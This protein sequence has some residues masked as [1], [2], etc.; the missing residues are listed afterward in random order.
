MARQ[1]NS[2]SQLPPS[3]PRISDL[4]FRAD[5]VRFPRLQPAR[6]TAHYDLHIAALEWSLDA[7]IT[8]GSAA[9]I[10]S[11]RI[12]EERFKPYA[13]QVRNLITFCRRA[14]VALFADDVGL[15]KTISAGLVLSE[16][17]ERRK[18]SRALVVAPRI[19]LP[20]WQEELGTKFDIPSSTAT[21]SQLADALRGKAPVVITT[22][23]SVRGHLD[24]IGV[25]D[26]DMVIL[27]E[28][29]KLRNLHGTA[30]A[31]EFALSVRQ[32]LEAR[33]FKYVLMLTA[34]PIQN[35]LWDLYSLVDLLTVAKG[36]ENPLGSPG[37]F[38]ANYV[39]DTMAVEIRHGRREQF[40]RHL[41]SYIVRTRRSDAKLVFPQ[42]KVKTERVRPEAVELELLT[43]VGGLFRGG[44]LNGLTQSS[45]GQALMSSPAALVA[46]LEEMANRKTVPSSVARE[47]AALV[48][49]NV[50]SGKLKGL[51]ALVREL[52]EARPADWR[53]VV[54][55]SRSKTQEMV[56]RH[57]KSLGIPV[58]YIAGGRASENERSIRAFRKKTPEV[59]VLISTDAGAE[60]IN[61]QV[62]N[63]LVNYDLPWNP[64][65]L[66]QRIGRIQRLASE[67]A[68]VNILNLVLK[69][70]VEE[71]VVGRLGEK[72]HA[73]A[74]SMG[75]IEGI[76]ETTWDADGTDDSFESMIRK[77]VVDSL[78]GVDVQAAMRKAMA[79][80]QEAQE[81]YEAERDTVEKT[82]GDLEDW[83]RVGAKVPDIS[84]VEPSI[85]AK[86]F[87][88][89]A[90]RADGAFIDAVEDEILSVAT[91]GK[92]RFLMTFDPTALDYNADE[93]L[94]SG[95]RPRLFL[96]GKRDF[97]RLAQNWADKSGALVVDR[98]RPSVAQLADAVSRWLA[99]R[100]YVK[101]SRVTSKAITEG[102]EGE[103]TCRASVAVA[104]DRLEKLV[105]VA[106]RRGPDC[107]VDPP[108]ASEAFSDEH[109]E[110]RELGEGLRALVTEAI[111]DEPDLARFADFYSKRL[112]EEIVS[113]ADE[114][115]RRG[116]RERFTPAIGAEAV[117]VRG[118]R[119]A[120][121]QVE[122][123]LLIDGEGPYEA[124]FQIRTAKFPYDVEAQSPWVVC[125]Q[126]HREVPL[127]ATAVCAISDTRALS[128]LLAESPVSHR[129]A[130]ISLMHRCDESG[131]LLLPHEIETCGVT[132]RRV[133]R[134][135][136][137]SSDLSGRK[138][139]PGELVECDFTGSKVLP[140]ELAVS[141]VSGRR[142]RKDQLARS[143]LTQ[144]QGHVSEFVIATEPA[145][146]LAIDEAGR[147]AVSGRWA[148]HGVLV[149]SEVAPDRLG[150]PDE[151]VRSVVS[152]RLGLLDEVDR[153]A[154]SAQPALLS[155]F[156]RCA[157]TGSHCLPGELVQSAVSGLQFR[158]D[159]SRRSVISGRIA[160]ESEIVESID[161]QG[162]LCA[163]EAARSGVSGAWVAADRLVASAL[164]PERRALPREMV[165]SVL[166]GALMM[167]DEARRSP[168]SQRPA[169]PTEFITCE[170]TGDAVLPDELAPSAVSGR[171][172]RLD[173]IVTSVVSGRT[174]HSSEFVDSCLPQGLI[175]R[176]EAEQSV[177]SGAT[178]ARSSMVQSQE[179]PNRWALPEETTTSVVSGGV[180][181]RDEAVFS[182]LGGGPAARRELVPCEF[183]GD[184]LLPT[185]LSASQISG[186]RFR[187]DQATKSVHSGRI[188]HRSEFV[189][190]TLPQG[191]IAADEA[192]TSALSG[193]R[194]ARDAMLVSAAAGERIGLPEEFTVSAVSGER[195]LR[196]E[197]SVSAVSGSPAGPGELSACG[198]TGAQVLPSE[199]LRSDISRKLFRCDEATE[200]VV[201]GR[202][203]HA[204]EF[205]PSVAPSGRI[206]IDEA[207]RS[208]LSGEWG[209]RSQ[210]VASARQPHRIGLPHQLLECEI[211][212]R[213]LL[214]D[215]LEPSVVS[216]RM[217]DSEL[218]VASEA[219]GLR[220]LAEE[221]IACEA[222]GRRILPQEAGICAITGR[223]VDRRELSP[224]A[225]S[226]REGLMSKLVRC[227]E[228]KR[229]VLPSELGR[230]AVSG[231]T[232]V[233]AELSNCS[234]TER[235]VLKRLLKSCPTTGLL[236]VDDIDSIRATTA[237]SGFNELLGTCAWTGRQQLSV[238][239][240]RCVLTK[241]VFERELMNL[242]G[243]LAMLRRLVNEEVAAGSSTLD[244]SGISW[245]RSAR[246]IFKSVQEARCYTNPAGTMSI[247]SVQVR[248]GFLGLGSAVY[249]LAIGRSA[250]LGFL[251]EPVAGKR[252]RGGWLRE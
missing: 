49:P 57:L 70:S 162:P 196:D 200:S 37:A 5:S 175:A 34:T 46:Q 83:H 228:T 179:Q 151:L 63:V 158:A 26:F 232:V 176:D 209:A 80:I 44:R 109:C 31:P 143:V 103:L 167:P 11:K 87:V 29:H 84:P 91:P 105:S 155:E 144:R 39:A 7:P 132:G 242:A 113:A 171:R 38:R 50:I 94:I 1:R 133:R 215:E 247:A 52:S 124:Q 227:E 153:S 17:M 239:L 161:P 73:I 198:F 203:G 211:S 163:D 30:K 10:Q 237:A 86:D 118:V 134:G 192:A 205:V 141:D 32:A 77:L 182:P 180:L 74:E 174:G 12:W 82:L 159:Q 42:R 164:S 236:Y 187:H 221:M 169:L 69:G 149:A 127:A 75:D 106:V 33:V 226:G 207:A 18:V 188:G 222:T 107:L 16:L 8:I 230:C 197:I 28:A 146:P 208:D 67:H 25:T 139:L 129:R 135:L 48:G 54:F 166:S 116:I 216:G 213:R 190:S 173:Q 85:E 172:F 95:N 114:A 98:A 58:G 234:L 100:T 189:Q 24:G 104:H 110:T 130:L 218:L 199:L 4:A 93:A 36:H 117:A 64:M 78:K 223:R 20:Q 108:Q 59:R 243:E 184:A 90:L 88:L 201:S 111:Q 2:R 241:L 6:S 212:R 35:R 160:H 99:P 47:A 168:I 193:T 154:V 229:L 240:G 126:T 102:F 145:G 152:G 249:A 140:D 185:E 245:L 156:Q 101:L 183:T 210:M 251:C 123:S 3:V 214:R 43:L 238:R 165:P 22:Y 61:L 244:A 122:A 181:L 125:G 62:A 14:P 97:E 202:K 231:R 150:L 112:E 92:A 40:R 51:V 76:L 204:S 121:L 9:D 96:P 191:L 13:H 65:I 248:T 131:S 136:L 137:L 147:S 56:G 235:T 120:V 128:H 195:F 60:G 45:I 55:T 224:S 177:I 186:K 72:L 252:G 23:H 246:E 19:L 217:V 21:G 148:S 178:A 115:G 66:E 119:H 41:G 68:E 157:I 170:I 15:G 81:I 79:S 142:F 219:S 233:F 89:S 27:D 225:V 53:L 206:A 250:R 220:A 71:L 194:A 138:A